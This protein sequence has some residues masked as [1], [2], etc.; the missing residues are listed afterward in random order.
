MP[1]RTNDFQQLVALVHRALA[2]TGAK[3][4]E[5]ALVPVP[6]LGG[7]REIDIL[8]ESE[9]GSYHIKMAIEAKD[10]RRKLDNTDIDEIIGKYRGVAGIPVD[11]IV[12]V[13]HRGFNNRAI[14]R[15]KME[16]I[17]LMTLAEAKGNKLN[18]ALNQSASSTGFAC[19]NVHIARLGVLPLID[20][21]K[22]P[23]VLAAGHLLCPCCGRSKATLGEAAREIVQNYL[24]PGSDGARRILKEAHHF[25]NGMEITFRHSVHAGTKLR[26]GAT[27]YPISHISIAVHGQFRE[28][29]TTTKTYD[30]G[31]ASQK[32]KQRLLHL[33][34]AVDGRALDLVIPHGSPDQISV[35][36]EKGFLENLISPAINVGPSPKYDVEMPKPPGIR[37]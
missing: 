24:A 9:C 16:N 22:D 7:V 26:I 15:A 4:T 8:M 10:H 17:E 13:S 11:K 28:T 21:V 29:H 33:K 32:R 36:F 5:S 31:S 19:A 30:F 20:E 3:I 12:I 25:P 18:T 37:F 34:Q 2:P 27:E 6:G 1:Q 14:A 35:R 23:A